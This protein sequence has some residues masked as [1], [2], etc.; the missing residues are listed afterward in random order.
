MNFYG[1]PEFFSYAIL[2]GIAVVLIRQD[3][4]THLRY[5]LSGWIIVLLHAA[6]YMLVIPGYIQNIV[7]RG[8]LAAAGF[9]FMLA[10]YYQQAPVDTPGFFR[11]LSLIGLPNML[12]AVLSTEYI[13]RHPDNHDF[14]LFAFIALAGL[15]CAICQSLNKFET[16]SRSRVLIALSCFVYAIQI[17][18]LYTYG[19]LMAS[20]WLM[21]W[22]YLA[23]AFFFLRQT[24][25]LTMGVSFTA[26]SFTLWGFVFPVYSLLAIYAPSISD[27]IQSLVWNLPKFLTAASMI[28]VL[29]EEKVL[30]ATQMATHDELTGLPNRRLYEDR[31]NLVLEKARRD[32]S[33]FAILII[34][35]NRFKQVNDTLGHHIGDLLLK[36]A[37]KRFLDALRKIDTVARTGGDEF[38]VILEGVNSLAEA[39]RVADN[40]RRTMELP[41]TLE[42]ALIDVGASIGAAIY[43]DDGIVQTELQAVADSRMYADKERSRRGGKPMAN[44]SRDMSMAS[45]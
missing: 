45:K 39:E 1:L 25:T 22:T 34:D 38:T 17:W 43:P 37:S 28:L 40:I 33:C 18:C 5:W 9:A 12:F 6:I 42:G 44:E 2:V 23:V 7:G 10:A 8:L 27:Q 13:E 15:V 26:L 36:T 20:Q 16:K 11:Q 31:Y 35:L 21:C 24:R 4:S 19:I 30:R 14:G 3:R 32:N 41:I 29:L